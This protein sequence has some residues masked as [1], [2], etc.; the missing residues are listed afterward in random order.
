VHRAYNINAQKVL[1][2]DIHIRFQVLNYFWIKNVNYT[3]IVSTVECGTSSIQKSKCTTLLKSV[4]NKPKFFNHRR[5]L[6]I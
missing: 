2:I 3:I 6:I 1:Y 5:I 4:L